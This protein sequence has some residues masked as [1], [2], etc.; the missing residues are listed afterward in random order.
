[1][2]CIKAF[3]RDPAGL[4]MTAVMRVLGLLILGAFPGLAAGPGK[5]SYLSPSALAIAKDGESLFVASATANQILRVNLG[6]RRV[7]SSFSTPSPPSGLALS[8]DDSRLFVTCGAPESEVII[9]GL[10]A[11]KILGR[12]QVGHTAS[13]PVFSATQ[14]RLFVCNRFG[15]SVNLIDLRSKS[16]VNR[17]AVQREPVAAAITADGGLL[18]VANLLP[19]GRADAD[20]VAAVVSVIDVAAGRVSKSLQLPDGS[21]S[22]HD[23]RISPDGRYA[24]VAHVLSRFRLPANQVERGWMNANAL[25]VIGVSKLEILNTV[26]LDDVDRGAA[27]PWGVAW[28]GDGVKVIIT[29][30]GTHEISVIDFPS[31]LAK[32]QKLPVTLDMPRPGDYG[33][34]ARVQ[35]DVPNDLSFL[36]G[37]RRRIKLPESDRGPRAVV[38]AGSTAYVANYFSDTLSVVDLSAVNPQ[39][40]SIP[41]GPRAEMSIVR[42]GEMYFCDGNLCLQ[43]WQSCSTCHPGEARMDGLNWDLPNDGIGNPKNTKSLLLAHKTPPAMSLGVRGTAEEAVRA[44]IRHILFA[45]QAEDVASAIDEYPQ[46][47]QAGAEPL[48]GPEPKIGSPEPQRRR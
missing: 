45:E 39:V 20:K 24:V 46:V 12:I 31:L 8:A 11:G 5:P 7:E 23:I 18:L 40:E 1:M 13:A 25:T 26:L 28:S 9:F 47:T 27:N 32:L 33:I 2:A 48:P 36:A 10:P 6:T 4:R 42:K 37:I 19:N 35:A 34:A 44:G 16:A 15:D 22:L 38:V 3:A 43:G 17:I 41:L 21:T 29:H 30:A 14:E